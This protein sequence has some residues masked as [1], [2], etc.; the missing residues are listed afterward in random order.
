MCVWQHEAN[1]VCHTEIITMSPDSEPQTAIIAG[2]YNWDQAFRLPEAWRHAES[3]FSHPW[4]AIPHH[5]ILSS[6]LLSSVDVALGYGTERNT[7]DLVVGTA[8]YTRTREHTKLPLTC[9]QNLNLPLSTGEGLYLEPNTD[10]PTNQPSLSAYIYPF[11]KP[12][13]DRSQNRNRNQCSLLLGAAVHSGCCVLDF[14]VINSILKD[15]VISGH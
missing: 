12:T 13:T 7:S 11:P 10:Q 3:W 8:A 1:N 5:P 2:K 14:V 6:P 15:Y 4:E 9:R